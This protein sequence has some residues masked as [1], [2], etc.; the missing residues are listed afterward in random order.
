MMKQ[1]GFEMQELTGCIQLDVPFPRVLDLCMAPGG[2]TSSVLRFNPSA[3]VL[4]LTL[5]D[6]CGGHRVFD[7][8]W[9]DGTAS[10][11]QI[12][13]SDHVG[14]GFWCGRLRSWPS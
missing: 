13:G 7:T 14:R 9:Q 5:P 11:S 1:I 4:G 12:C 10:Q 6:S 3:Q 8:L 2:Y